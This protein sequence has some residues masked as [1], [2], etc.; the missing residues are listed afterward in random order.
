ME[1][2]INL[3]NAITSENVFL[4]NVLSIPLMF[5]EV[6]LFFTLF[7]LIVEIE[8]SPKVK[9]TYIFICSIFCIITNLFI[10][11]PF[12]VFINYIFLFL[13]VHLLLHT[14]LLKS[15]ICIIIPFFLFSIVNALILNPFL[16]VFNISSEALQLIP[17][18]KISYLALVYLCLFI[19]IH[20][21]RRKSYN[22]SIIN[23]LSNNVDF[24]FSFTLIL[25]FFTLSVQ[26]IL[27]FY[28]INVVPTSITFINF[29][30]LFSYF[31][32]SFYSMTRTIRLHIA[33]RD[34]ENANSYNKSLSILYDNIKDFKH[35]FDNT[36]DIIGGYIKANDMEGLS[37]YYSGLRKDR[38]KLL[39]YQ[40]LN[41]YTINNPGIY[42]LIASKY[43][44]ATK[45]NVKINLD[46]FFD[47]TNLKMPIYEFS[48]IIGILID[49]AIEA[50]KDSK[51]KELNLTFRESKRNNVQIVSVE[52]SY[53]NK[54]VDIKNIFKKGVS[55]KENHTGLGL[56]EVHNIMMKNNNIT[57]HTTKNDKFFKQQ[58]EIYY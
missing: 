43:E 14:S 49:N 45:F 11:S 8:Y 55:G 47:F 1:I 6:S 36:M 51:E 33:T 22:F 38:V 18:Y 25:G 13:V 48:K 28:Y 15:L 32:M 2:L 56:W 16:K 26:T 3:W 40:V 23:N 50:A 17:I 52:N 12:N 31:V 21:I 4:I 30:F 7:T 27:T 34:L 19:I 44:K 42:N 41:P 10:P 57:L 39:N 35:D 53:S 5:I 29:V 46:I 54:D 9:Y 58:L 20:F 37:K 24:M